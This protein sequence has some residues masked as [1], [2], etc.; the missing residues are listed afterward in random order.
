VWSPE[1]AFTNEHFVAREFP[2]QVEHEDLGR[3][4]EYPGAPFRAPASPWRISRRAPHV[5]EHQEEVF[6]NP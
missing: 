1:E 2:V 5:A 6:G 4:F 3:S